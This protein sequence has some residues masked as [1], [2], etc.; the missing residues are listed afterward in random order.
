MRQKDE[1]GF[2]L[3]EIIMVV[4]VIGL[5]AIIAVPTFFSWLP[6]MRLKSAASDMYSNIQRA[7]LEAAKQNTC[8]GVSFPDATPATPVTDW[9]YTVFTDNGVG[10]ACNGTQDAGEAVLFT[11][12][13]A[14]DVVLHNTSDIGGTDAICFTPTTVICGSQ[15]GNIQLRNHTST[16]YYMATIGA[17]GGIRIQI[18]SDGS[19]WGN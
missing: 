19:T 7:K 10:T 13:V 17:A 8:T 18:S 4:V 9:S 5:M 16:R 3:I 11:N 1:T 12:A 2:T 15:S 14:N 6:N